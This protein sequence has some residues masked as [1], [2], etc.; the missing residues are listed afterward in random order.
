MTSESVRP[1]VLVVEDDQDTRDMYAMFLDYSG[2]TALTASNVDDAFDIAVIEQPQM[3]ITDY[4]LAGGAN[5]A[6]LCH[7]L[8]R[9][10]RTAHIP[11]L[12]LTGSARQQD[13]ESETAGCAQVRMKPY[14]PDALVDD[15]RATISRSS[16]PMPDAVGRRVPETP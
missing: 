1:V 10:P 4:R 2:I 9:D 13:A 14:L 5:G 12:L 8:H 11:T 15:I 16:V 7:R 6:E 3:V